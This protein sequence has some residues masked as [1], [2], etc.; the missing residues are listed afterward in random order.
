M[1]GRIVE[2][3]YTSSSNP[4]VIPLMAGFIRKVNMNRMIVYWLVAMQWIACSRVVFGQSRSQKITKKQIVLL[5]PE[6]DAKIRDIDLR[7]IWRMDAGTDSIQIEHYELFFLTLI[8]VHFFASARSGH[9]RHR[10]DFHSRERSS[11]Q[12][13]SG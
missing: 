6:E 8:D 12:S 1:D 4:Y 11:P 10:H 5:S 9:C 7:F 13:L 2:G 3:I